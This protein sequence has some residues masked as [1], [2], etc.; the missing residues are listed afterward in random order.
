MVQDQAVLEPPGKEMMGLSSLELIEAAVVA[1]PE[2][3]VI[4]MV[5]D[6][7]EMEKMTTQLGRQQHLLA[8]LDTLPEA[9]VLAVTTPTIRVREEME[10]VAQEWQARRILEGVERV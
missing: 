8:I 10:A 2:S 6:M 9:A 7:V 5:C 1:G 4:L 3:Q